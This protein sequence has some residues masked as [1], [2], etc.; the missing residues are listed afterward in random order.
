MLIAASQKDVLDELDEAQLEMDRLV[1]EKKAAYESK[2][3]TEL[4]SK[5]KVRDERRLWWE[6]MNNAQ[7][8]AEAKLES[9][10]RGYE[11]IIKHLKQKQS[12]DLGR[13]NVRLSDKDAEMDELRK[14]LDRQKEVAH[15]EK[16]CRR[17]TEQKASDVQAE[18]TRHIKAMNVW[19]MEIGD[20]LRVSYFRL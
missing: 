13:L 10:R 14:S 18:C 1:A 3:E 11:A 7:S 19:L 17:K 12:R 2:V 20:E 9:D 4:D 16:Q 6:K 5:V 15:E 8:D